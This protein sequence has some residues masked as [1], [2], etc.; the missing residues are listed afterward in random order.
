MQLAPMNNG[1][2]N[3]NG[4]SRSGHNRVLNE[5]NVTPFVDVML[6]LLIIFMVTAPL[7]QQGLPVNLPQAAA[8]AL[9]RTKTDVIITIKKDGN[10][11]IGDDPTVIPLPEL[12]ERLTSL[13]ATKEDKDLFIKAD[14]DL[15]Y[16]MVVKVMS[17]AK[18]AGVD[19]IGMLTQPEL[20]K[21]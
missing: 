9:K 17:I 15:R 1:N 21:R 14:T 13:Y 4:K 8:P 6:V 11:F 16:G 20:A 5:I 3:A 12:E 7:M 2:G 18:K 19:R 10:I